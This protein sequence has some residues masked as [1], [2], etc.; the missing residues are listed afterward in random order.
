MPSWYII[1]F[2]RLPLQWQLWLKALCLYS[3]SFEHNISGAPAYKFSKYI[4]NAHF[5]N[6]TWLDFLVTITSPKNLLN[7]MLK[8]TVK[9]FRCPVLPGLFVWRIHVSELQLLSCN[10]Y[11]WNVIVQH[12]LFDAVIE[13]QVILVAPC[14]QADMHGKYNCSGGCKHQ[15]TRW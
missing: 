5:K 8:Q 9:V 3:H 15:T 4:A 11:I 10:N 14:E 13:L 6:L 2:I 1:I 12:W 7:D